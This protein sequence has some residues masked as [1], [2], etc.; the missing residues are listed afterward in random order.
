MHLIPPL[1]PTQKKMHNLC[2]SF[3]LGVT[4]LPRGIEKKVLMKNLGG[5]GG[6]KY[7]AL[8]LLKPSEFIG[9]P[10]HEAPLF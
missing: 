1:S 8:W 2:F 3:L 7:G 10:K 9:S 5:G 4:A 6:G